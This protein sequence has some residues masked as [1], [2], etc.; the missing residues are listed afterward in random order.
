MQTLGV[1]QQM[2]DMPQ[3]QQCLPSS[4]LRTGGWVADRWQL[5]ASH[6]LA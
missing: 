6:T 5:G 2:G 4:P 1:Q 3:H